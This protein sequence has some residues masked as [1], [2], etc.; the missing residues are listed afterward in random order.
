MF[1]PGSSYS[2]RSKLLVPI[3]LE[4]I[5]CCGSDCVQS[6]SQ[7]LFFFFKYTLYYI[8]WSSS[9]WQ[10][11]RS[12]FSLFTSPFAKVLHSKSID[13]SVIKSLPGAGTTHRWTIW[14]TTYFV[15]LGF[16]SM[17]DLFDD[18]CSRRFMVELRFCFIV[19]ALFLRDKRWSISM[20]F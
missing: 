11:E 5:G 9:G 2:I 13:R 7:H 19:I 1:A 10:V 18:S 3:V 15:P 12:T 20:T 4:F 16:S 14:G 6:R 17:M 8:T